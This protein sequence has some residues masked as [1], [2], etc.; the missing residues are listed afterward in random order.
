MTERR[1]AGPAIEVTGLT[2][3]FGEVAAVEDLSFAVKPG[4]V[5]GFLGPNGAGKTTTLRLILGLL[6]PTSGRATVA[7]RPYAELDDPSGMVGSFIDAGGFHPGRKGR[8]ALRV[9]AAATGVARARVDEVL[10]IVGLT[11]AAHRRVGT[12]ST[13]M[14]QRL[15]LAR[16]LLGDPPALILDEPANGLD[17]EGI[18]WLRTLLRELAAE[19]RTVLVSSHVLAEVAQT[20]DDVVIL[21]RGRFVAQ[22]DVSSLTTGD[23]KAEARTPRPDDLREALRRRGL[24]V[25]RGGDGLVRVLEATPEQV[26]AVSAEEGI[27]L[28]ELGPGATSLEDVFLELTEEA[29]G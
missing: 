1:T 12:Y 2:K 5:T 25:E 8:D 20:A 7:G 15:G 18:R 26:W 10:E 6:K 29:D 21:R 16:A 19:G 22:S 28:S 17:P 13:G 14:R 3:R 4:R 23:S 24:A 9:I 11:T 27:P